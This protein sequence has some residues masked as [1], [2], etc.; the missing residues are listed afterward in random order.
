MTAREL[1]KTELEPTPATGAASGAPTSNG[2]HSMQVEAPE[3]TSRRF[4]R[5]GV[6]RAAFWASLAA[7]LGGGAASLLNSIYPRGVSGF[8]GAVAVPA[9]AIPEPGG[10]PRQILEGR[11][12]LVH[13][14][15]DEGRVA[16]DAEPA[17]GGL[18]AL[19]WKCPHLGCTVPWK[20]GFTSPQF[21]PLNRRGFFNCNCHGSTYTK[22][23]A[24]VKG[25]A[26]RAMDTMEIEVGRDGVVVRTDKI[27]KGDNSNPRRAVRWNDGGGP[28]RID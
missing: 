25:P 19:W 9:A 23:G 7:M 3:P 14:L 20:E 11:C 28:S 21:D 18:V 27:V 8:G 12:Y 6:L 4:G 1:T 13:L 26:S 24:L 5:R 16:E 2:P 22:A 10:A 17:P 15:P